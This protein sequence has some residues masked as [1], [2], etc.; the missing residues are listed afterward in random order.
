MSR[1]PRRMAWLVLLAAF[2]IHC[3]LAVSV[4]LTIRW[5]LLNATIGHEAMVEPIM[6]TVLVWEPGASAPIGV[7][8]S[9]AVPEGS[10][11]RTDSSSRAFITFFD[12]STAT[13]SFDTDTR[14]VA[15]RSPRFG[16]SSKPDSLYLDITLGQVNIGVA[17]PVNRPVDFRATSPHMTALLDEGS[18]S[19]KVTDDSSRTIVH[20]GTAHVTAQGKTVALTQ[21]ERT[22]VRDGQ[23]PAEPV[24]APQNLLVNGSFQEELAVGWQAYNEQGGDGGDVDGEISLVE[25]PD[26][27]S[28]ALRFFRTGS[29]G[30]H[31]ETVI[32]QELNEEISDLATSISLYLRVKLLDQSLSG[33]GYLSSEYP[34]MIR[35]EYEDVYGS[36]SHWTHGFYYQNEDNNPTMYGERITYGTWFDYASGNI[37]EGIYPRPARLKSLLIYASGWDYESMVTD[38]S[39]VVE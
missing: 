31:C 15:M 26:T 18:Y 21:P 28:R 34:V 9:L 19:L 37:L 36:E 33:G 8:S 16:F 4:P 17:L 24:A 11:I 23:P 2:G 10:R 39:L 5:Y 30:N 22:T 38:I 14:L 12:N 1:D 27:T 35:L 7:T 32:R 25:L 3:L 29:G 6:G 13:V 20:L